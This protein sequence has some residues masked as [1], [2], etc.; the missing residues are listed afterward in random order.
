MVADFAFGRTG[1]SLPKRLFAA[2]ALLLH[3]TCIEVGNGAVAVVLIGGLVAVI[4]SILAKEGSTRLGIF[5]LCRVTVEPDLAGIY[6]GVWLV[7]IER[8]IIKDA[9]SF[10]L[11]F[12]FSTH[13]N[14]VLERFY[15][16]YL[17][18]TVAFSFDLLSMQYRYLFER[19]NSFPLLM[20]GLAL[21]S[22][23]SEA[24]LLCTNC[25]N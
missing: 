8:K 24:S 16:R 9:I 4:L 7:G 1:N 25:S 18:L 17:L 15:L 13:F 5:C 11:K 20:A 3:Q 21:K 6:D 23:S 10:A 14:N 2:G 12:I 19:R 22:E